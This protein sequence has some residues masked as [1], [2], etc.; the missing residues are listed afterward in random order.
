MTPVVATKLPT[1][2]ADGSRTWTAVGVLE[3]ASQG[4]VAHRSTA[5]NACSWRP[6]SYD[7]APPATPNSSG[8]W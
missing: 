2:D 3:K 6:P 8:A 4:V 5:P 1:A 7:S